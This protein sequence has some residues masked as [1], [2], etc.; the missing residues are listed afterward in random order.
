MIQYCGGN[1]VKSISQNNI[2]IIDKELKEKNNENITSE[3]YIYDCYYM[4]H[5]FNE[6]E[7]CYHFDKV[8]E[9]K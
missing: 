3:E 9:L 1:V 2:I 5:Q 4:L 8:I 6:K 7:K